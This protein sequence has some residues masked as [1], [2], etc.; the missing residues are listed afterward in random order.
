MGKFNDTDI[1]HA[2]LGDE[3]FLGA[4]SVPIFHASTYHQPNPS[5]PPSYRYSRTNSPTRDTLEKVIAKLEGGTRGFAFSSGVAAI[6]SVFMTFKH[7]DHIIAPDD[8]YGGT[9]SLLTE[10]FVRWGLKSTFV[11]MTNPANIE[12]AITKDTVAI[13][14]ETPSN[15]FLCI[16]DL[17][18]VANIA[19]KHKL[20]TIID[21]TFS[22][23][24]L[25]KPFD[26]DFDIVIHSATKFLGGH[27]DVLAGVVVTRD[28]A[29]GAQ[30]S[31]VQVAFGAVLDPN[32]SWLLLRGIKT[33]A[34]RMK[35]SQLGAQIV[36]EALSKTQGIKKVYYPGLESH[37]GYEVH[38]K[39]ARGAGAVM[40]FTLDDNIEPTKFFEAIKI[41]IIAVSLGGVETILSYPCKMSHNTMPADERER[42]GIT[43]RFMRLSI[44][45]E[46]PADLI[47][48]I[49]DA[50]KASKN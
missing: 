36:A 50:L 29:I 11:D 19:K 8:I 32:S 49:K 9:F 4:S 17:S 23:P 20:T 41:P 44:G 26:Y 25:Q 18:A 2:D 35:Q 15:P 39:Q 5:N 10:L 46:E 45:L 37:Q 24:Y 40:S 27:S 14:V 1:I 12:K 38:R 7:G 30:V 31:N 33:L 42:R 34:V 43:E 6:A 28:K 3:R 48:D 16:T 13:Y 22:S 47:A 21:N